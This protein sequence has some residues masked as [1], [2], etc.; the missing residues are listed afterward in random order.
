MD[1]AGFKRSTINQDHRLV[2][3]D[4]R[5]TLLP[6]PRCANGYP[7]LKWGKL[8]YLKYLPFRNNQRVKRKN[9]DRLFLKVGTN[10]P[11]NRCFHSAN[12]E[13]REFN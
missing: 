12:S 13:A 2:G 1:G 5:S 3:V 11:N 8:K 7:T 9:T 6:L 10:F 4:T